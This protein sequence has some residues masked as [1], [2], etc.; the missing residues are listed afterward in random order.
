MF[1]LGASYYFYMCWKAEY[2]IIIA[3]GT[4][5]DYY[6]AIA[7]SRTPSNSRKKLYLYLS[8]FCNLGALFFFKYLN[9]FSDTLKVLL[10]Q[11]NIFYN[12]RV[13]NLLLPIGI[14]YYTFKKISY[15]VDV[16]R[17]N[18]EPE[19]HLGRFSLFV[20]FFPAL[21]TG[22]ID[23]AKDLLP[24]FARAFNFKYERV[25]NGLKLIIWGLFK[26]VVVADRLAIFADYVFNHPEKCD[27]S[28]L[29]MAMFFYSVQIYADFSGYTDMAIGV[30]QVLGYRL[31]DNFNRPYFSKSISQ[32]WKRW[33]IS[34]SSWLMDYLFLPIAYAISRRIKSVKLLYIKAETWAYVIGIFIT[35]LLCGLWHGA[36]WTYVIWGG[37]HGIYMV[38]AFIT[39]KTRKK[40]RKKIKKIG[41][42]ISTPYDIARILFT[43]FAVSFLWIFFRSDSI[44]RS[45]IY[46]R[47]MMELNF[48]SGAPIADIL[49][50]ING[51][52]LFE[53]NVAVIAICILLAFHLLEPHSTM[54]N[55]LEGRRPLWYRWAAYYI[56]LFSIIFFSVSETSQF[57]YLRF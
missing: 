1:L 55:M 40:I 47:R 44:S 8:L 29:F 32:F 4:L 28:A 21:A 5:V 37:L 52:D 43:F 24:Q 9:F 20:S 15:V 14:S 10:S 13:F 6:I 42:W 22:P 30:A 33:H 7:I 35:M 50:K 19:R 51:F 3:L 2:V 57:I 26:K 54:R 49:G 25:I 46:I 36:K 23:R 48:S 11:F 53:F 12:A 34:L 38:L 56:I 18:Q 27:S 16:Y 31:T 45:V 41:K 39:K 17:E